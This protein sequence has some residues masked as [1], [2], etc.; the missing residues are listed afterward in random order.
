MRLSGRTSRVTVL[1]I[2]AA[3]VVAAA[4]GAAA[5]GIVS[6]K[7]AIFSKTLTRSSCTLP[8]TAVTADTSTDEQHPGSAA[9][10]T[11]TTLAVSP[12]AGRR[13]YAWIAF[14]PGG[15]TIPQDAQVDSARLT[16]TVVRSASGST[17]SVSAADAAWSE[18]T[19]WDD[20][21]A[22]AA[23]PSDTFAAATAG[24]KSVDVTADAAAWLAGAA[25]NYGWRLADLGA[26]ANVTP[27]IAASEYPTAASRP[28]LS[29]T[30][31]S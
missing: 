7:I 21:P 31:A 14:G 26:S 17:I 13:R 22:A 9:D 27:T 6:G 1:A 8:A 20:Q 24:A 25:P 28:T 16:L 15:C 10:G 18:A 29:V 19:A 30:F 2:V 4:A 12:R 23:T 11:A 5:V 3:A